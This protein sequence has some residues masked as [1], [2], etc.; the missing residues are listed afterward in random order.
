MKME[1]SF[2]EIV[3]HPSAPEGAAT[4]WQAR[5]QKTEEMINALAVAGVMSLTVGVAAAQTEMP[6]ALDWKFE[7]PAAPYTLAV[8]EGMFKDQ[9]LEVTI[10]KGNGLL[11]AIPKVATGA[12][13]ALAGTGRSRYRRP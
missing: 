5:P 1:A 2:A 8:D 6:F 12:F 7:G 11:D 3:L 4:D 13:P 10:T 9:G